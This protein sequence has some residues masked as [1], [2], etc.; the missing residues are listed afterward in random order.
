MAVKV[1]GKVRGFSDNAETKSNSDLY[2]VQSEETPTI[3]EVWEIPDSKRKGGFFSAAKPTASKYEN[4]LQKEKKENTQKINHSSDLNDVQRP[5]LNNYSPKADQTDDNET[6][7][8]NKEIAFFTEPKTVKRKT[9]RHIFGF[10]AVTA[11]AVC[12]VMLLLKFF[13]PELYDNLHFYYFRLF[14]W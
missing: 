5:E 4:P 7:L 14:Q 1:T 9:Q 11:A 10:Q 6:E 13:A 3:R 12:L 2:N 8:E